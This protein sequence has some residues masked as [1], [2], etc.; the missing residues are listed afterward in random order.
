[1]L[2]EMSRDKERLIYSD[3]QK[4]HALI[5]VNTLVDR[6]PYLIGTK[7]GSTDTAR[8]SVIVV[9]EYPIGEPHALI[10]LGAAPGERFV[11]AARLLNRISR[12]LP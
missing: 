5:N 8:D 11:E 12:V 3:A 6:I 7:T 1:M 2:W 9:Y 4:R 10:L